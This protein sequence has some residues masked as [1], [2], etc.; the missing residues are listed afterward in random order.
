MKYVAFK[1]RVD[2]PFYSHSLSSILAVLSSVTQSFSSLNTLQGS[3][4]TYWR[5]EKR[6]ETPINLL[7]CFS[8][9]KS[10][11]GFPIFLLKKKYCFR[12]TRS[13]FP[14]LTHSSGSFTRILE[15]TLKHYDFRENCLRYILNILQYLKNRIYI[16]IVFPQC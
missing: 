6:Y 7:I 4:P 10:I 15:T 11:V 5:K 12:I 14:F 8:F 16:Y 1:L 9:F 13:T 2:A 3:W